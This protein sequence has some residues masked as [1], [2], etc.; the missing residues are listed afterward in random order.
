MH[1]YALAKLKEANSLNFSCMAQTVSGSGEKKRVLG[2]KK[3][4]IWDLVRQKEI[5]Q[6]ILRFKEEKQN[7]ACG[8]R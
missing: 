4:S 6:L 1:A 5:K 7:I 8:E 3:R 2:G